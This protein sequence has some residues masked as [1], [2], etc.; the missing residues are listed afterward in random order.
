MSVSV[1]KQFGNCQIKL[2]MP[3]KTLPELLLNAA[4]FTQNDKCACG[5]EKI[6]LQGHKAQEYVFI[7]RECQDCR[8]V[9]PLGSYKTGGHYWKAWEEPFN[10]AD[11]ANET[12]S[13]VQAPQ[14][15]EATTDEP[16]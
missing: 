4:I 13:T 12:A 9:S 10:K 2:E 8:K 7:N 1:T 11:A 6:A 3:G 5:G 16:W 14:T 15:A